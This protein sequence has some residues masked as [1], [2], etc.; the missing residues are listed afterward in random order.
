MAIIGTFNKIIYNQQKLM[1][2]KTWMPPKSTTYS[3]EL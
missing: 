2:T 3:Q 1:M